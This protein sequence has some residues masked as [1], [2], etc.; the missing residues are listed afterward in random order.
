MWLHIVYLQIGHSLN[1]WIQEF[2]CNITVEKNKLTMCRVLCQGYAMV[3]QP[4]LTDFIEKGSDIQNPEKEPAK[5]SARKFRKPV[6][7]IIVI[8]VLALTGVFS[9]RFMLPTRPG[10]GLIPLDRKNV[11][12]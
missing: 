3:K 1:L 11:F 4:R 5:K 9:V 2:L 7:I 12:V 10:W 6:L 8:L